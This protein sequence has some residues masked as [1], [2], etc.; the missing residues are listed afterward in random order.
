MATGW[1]TFTD[2][3]AGRAIAIRAPA[4]G[5]HGEIS[6]RSE[7]E[8]GRTWCDPDGNLAVVEITLD[9]TTGLPVEDLDYGDLQATDL[10]HAPTLGPGMGMDGVV[11]SRMA[12]ERD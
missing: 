9:P 1:L 2:F 7:S 3:K 4:Q 5:H 11:W 8:G 12:A 6:L 10:L